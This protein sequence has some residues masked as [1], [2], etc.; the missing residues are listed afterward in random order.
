[1]SASLCPLR[2]LILMLISRPGRW[3]CIERLLLLLQVPWRWLVLLIERRRVL[4]PQR[5]LRVGRLLLR[6]LLP[7]RVLLLRVG[8]VLL[9]VL[10]VR[11]RPR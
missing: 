6:V 1:M 11:L 2:S 5:L 7:W 9:L 8:I 10:P 4:N 3:W